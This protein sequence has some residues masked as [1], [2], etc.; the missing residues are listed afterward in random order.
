M[1][2]KD[3]SRQLTLELQPPSLS[4]DL[5]NGVGMPPP[6]FKSR[7]RVLPQRADCLGCHLSNSDV[8][9]WSA[10]TSEGRPR[11]KALSY[12]RLRAAHGFPNEVPNPVID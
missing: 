11:W 8:Q 12:I 7:S 10:N 5:K 1:Q 3:T 4:Q 2:R 6:G 9:H